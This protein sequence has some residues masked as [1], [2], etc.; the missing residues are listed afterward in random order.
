MCYIVVNA[1]E[2]FKIDYVQ[3]KFASII[4]TKNKHRHDVIVREW[5]VF[6]SVLIA[7]TTKKNNR[8]SLRQ[9][10]STQSN[11][12]PCIVVSATFQFSTK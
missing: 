1:K 10:K 2:I 3:S 11:Y 7:V 12:D 9:L 8:F 5:W 6:L 4:A